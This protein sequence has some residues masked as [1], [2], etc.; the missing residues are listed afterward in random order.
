MAEIPIK[1]LYKQI[2]DNHVAIT[3]LLSADSLTLAWLRFRSI[4]ALHGLATTKI[5][6][7]KLIIT[8]RHNYR[9]YT[10]Y[11][12]ILDKLLL[13]TKHKPCAFVDIVE[14]QNRTRRSSKHKTAKIQ[15]APPSTPDNTPK[16]ANPP[17]PL[18]QTSKDKRVT[19]LQHKHKTP[20]DHELI[21]FDSNN[22]MFHG[23]NTFSDIAAAP[24]KATMA[25]EMPE[26]TL[27]P[28]ASRS[29]NKYI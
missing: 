7:G 24:Q 2:T 22:P 4:W 5:A 25:A 9:A 10:E 19:S 15:S 28:A 1:V 23:L 20:H 6:H 18:R 17:Q 13:G 26:I 29:S 14:I 8:C 16:P 3:M 21:I 11:Q 12:A 27:I